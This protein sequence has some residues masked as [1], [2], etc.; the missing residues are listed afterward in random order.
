MERSTGQLHTQT[1][2][3]NKLKS[4]EPNKLKSYE[5]WCHPH[6]KA[7]LFDITLFR[8]EATTLYPLHIK[9]LS[10]TSTWTLVQVKSNRARFLTGDFIN[11]CKGH[12]D[13]LEQNWHSSELHVVMGHFI[14]SSGLPSPTHYSKRGNS[15]KIPKAQSYVSALISLPHKKTRGTHRPKCT[16]NQGLR[17][18]SDLEFHLGDKTQGLICDQTISPHAAAHINVQEQR[19]WSN[20]SSKG[21]QKTVSAIPSGM[22]GGIGCGITLSRRVFHHTSRAPN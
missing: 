14:I 10:T 17:S 20:D 1:Q 19:V 13:I 22:K 4:Y 11:F 18:D 2:R 5:R 21:T 7:S 6:T 12:I 15:C 16:A 3:P 9:C 8:L